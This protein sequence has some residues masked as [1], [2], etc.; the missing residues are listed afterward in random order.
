VNSL[1]TVHRRK[2]FQTVENPAFGMVM[3]L[4]A[5][6]IFYPIEIAVA[7]T[8]DAVAGLPLQLLVAK[9]DL[10]IHFVGRRSFQL[11]DQFAY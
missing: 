5:N 11:T 10:L 4:V 9:T 3:A 7:E 8:H 6:V 1:L 2:S